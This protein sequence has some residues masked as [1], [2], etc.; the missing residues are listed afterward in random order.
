MPRKKLRIG[1]IPVI[2]KDLEEGTIAEA[3]NDGTIFLDKDVKPDSPLGREAIAHEKV[4][5]DQMARGDL[6]YDDN[7]VYWKGKKY[8]R[9]K[10]AEGAKN[11]P[12]EAEAYNKTEHMKKSK[13]SPIH[14]SLGLSQNTIRGN[15]QTLNTFEDS[16]AG[17]VAMAG[18]A[19]AGGLKAAKK[20]KDAKEGAGGMTDNEREGASGLLKMKASPITQKAKKLQNLLVAANKLSP[21]K[22]TVAEREFRAQSGGQVGTAKEVTTGKPGE[23]KV[24]KTWAQAWADN[25]EDIKNKYDSYEEYVKSRKAQRDAD[26]EGYEKDLVDKTGVSGGPG[27]VTTKGNEEVET[28]FTP[29][30]ETKRGKYNMGY[31][32]AMDAKWGEGVMHRDR[33]QNMRKYDRFTKQFNKGKAG[34]NPETGKPFESAHEFASYKLGGK[35]YDTKYNTP[36][37]KRGPDSKG[38]VDYDPTKHGD[39][40]EVTVGTVTKETNSATDTEN[41]NEKESG[42]K[43]KKNV[44]FKMKGW[45]GYNK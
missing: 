18:K 16:A 22:E 24:R 23:T 11:L 20:A 44:P 13:K 19:V 35:D 3:N 25:D 28:T 7:N 14:L 10:M 36:V 15:R 27:S 21:L 45:S 8:P 31:E 39:L 40:Q 41:N 38:N 1:K 4:H 5:M 32:E 2:K 34:M 33:K 26:P 30:E 43:M 29:D 37:G 42:A 9:A 17:K 6:N 12:W